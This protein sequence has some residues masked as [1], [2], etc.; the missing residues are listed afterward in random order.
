[1]TAKGCA[2]YSNSRH[3][4]AIKT[5]HSSSIEAELI[6]SSGGYDGQKGSFKPAPL[7]DCPAISDPLTARPAPA[8]GS[9]DETNLVLN[10]ETRPLDP[11]VYCGGLTI[12]G[13]S[14]ITFES[15]IYVMKDGPLLVEDS[16]SVTGEYTGFFFTGSDAELT[17]ERDTTVELSAPR[18]GDMAGLLFF[19]DAASADKK[20]RFQVLS[21]DARILLGTIYLP[22]AEFYVDATAPIADQSAYTVIIAKK[23]LLSDG[24]DLVLNTD[25]GLT[26][27]PVPEGVLSKSATISLVK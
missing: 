2:V 19:Q 3:K 1:M 24:P 12:K 9:C 27:V 8:A 15:G 10:N 25:Y 14:E 5:F 11:G 4:Q 16:A 13:T 18:D 22:V 6:C 26:D 7:T 21:N 17:I 20:S 23:F